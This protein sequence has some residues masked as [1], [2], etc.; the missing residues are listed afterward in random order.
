MCV[1]VYVRERARERMCVRTC[2][3]KNVC[4]SFSKCERAPWHE[5]G[6]MCVI[7]GGKVDVCARACV[8]VCERERERERE[9]E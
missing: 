4:V 1:N 2:M 9:R 5:I 6:C 7:D 3:L 8:C